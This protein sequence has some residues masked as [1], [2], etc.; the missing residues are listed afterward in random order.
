[1]IKDK[2]WS[3]ALKFT[4]AFAGAGALII[5]LIKLAPIIT[6][7]VIAL[8]IVYLLLPPVRFLISRRFP[9]LLAAASAVLVVL[10]FMFLF[11]YLLIPGLIIEL[12]ELANFVTSEVVGEWP[13]FIEKLSELDARFNLQLAEKLTE[14]YSAFTSEAPGMVQQLLKHLANFSMALVSKAWMGLMLIFLVFYLVQDLERAKNNLTLLAPRIYQKDV[15][16]ILGIVDQK[17]GAF[18]RGTLTRSL[19]VGLLTGGGLAVVGLP[20]AILLGALAGIFNIV[21]Y[22]GPVLAAVPGLLLS[23]LPGSPNFFL[24]LAVYVIPQI[25]DGF[26]FTPLLLGKAVDLSPLTVITVILIGGQLAGITGI[27]LAVPLSA[28]LKVLLVDYY[29]AKKKI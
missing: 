9:P 19:F 7:F 12:S 11:F 17:V 2:E 29:L 25:L 27:I 5:M 6:I 3:L 24:I 28:I 15:V 26:V 8:F 4:L 22:I 23:L 21:L 10:F 20:F 16:H 13:E 1:M 18:I 14:Y